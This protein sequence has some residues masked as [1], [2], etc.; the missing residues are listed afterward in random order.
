MEGAVIMGKLDDLVEK[1]KRGELDPRG[2]YRAL[3]E[4]LGSLAQTLK[5]EDISEDDIRS[6]IPLLLTFLYDQADKLEKRH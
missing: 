3:L 5:D 2:F 4:I 6:Q 1:R